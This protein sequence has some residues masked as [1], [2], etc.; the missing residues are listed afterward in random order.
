MLFGL[1]NIDKKIRA[2]DSFPA[3]SWMLKISGKKRHKGEGVHANSGITAKRNYE[4]VFI[5]L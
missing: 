1:E 5:F 2:L 3:A 4:Q